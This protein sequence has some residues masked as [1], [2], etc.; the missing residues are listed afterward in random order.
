ME[1]DF[2]IVFYIIMLLCFDLLV[3]GLISSASYLVYNI[4]RYVKT[5]KRSDFYE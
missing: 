3:L 1:K 4:L 5:L 2:A